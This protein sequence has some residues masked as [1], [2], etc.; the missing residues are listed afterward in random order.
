[1][2]RQRATSLQIQLACISILGLLISLAAAAYFSGWQVKSDSNLIAGDAVPGT[3]QAHQMRMVMTRGIGWVMVAASA[4]TAQSRD[5]SLKLA[6]DA[7]TAFEDTFRQYEATVLINPEEDKALLGRLKGLYAEFLTQRRAYEALILAG[8]K[9]KSAAFLE[10]SLVP[11]FLPAIEAAEALLNY[12]HANSIALA[13]SIQRSVR[14]LYWAVAVV[15]VMAL[16]CAGVLMVNVSIRR[17]ELAQLQE[18]EEKFSKVFKCSLSGIAITELETGRYLEVNESFCRIMGCSPREVIGRTSLE[19][20]IWM[21]EEERSQVFQPLFAG[22][23]LRGLERQMRIRGGTPRNLCINIELIELGGKRCM[24]SLI[25]DITE[26]KAADQKLQASEALFRTSFESA[27]VGVC[28]VATDGRFLNVN[29]TLCEMLGYTR[30]ELLQ[31]TFNDITHEEDKGLGSTFLND[32]LAGGAKQMQTEKRYLH[33]DGGVVWAFLSTALVEPSR[34]HEGYLISYVQDITERKRAREQL[35][36]LK[37]SIDTHLD[38]AFWM[39]TNNRFVYVNDSACE[40]LGYSREELLGQPV[41]LVA[42]H[43]T[44][45]TLDEVWE[46]LRETGFF[47]CESTHRRKDGSEFPVEIIASYVRFEG[48]EFN[49]GFARDITERKRLEQK[50][51]ELAAIVASSEDAIIGKSLTGVITSWN[52][53][54]ENIFGYSAEE[55]IGRPLL[56]LIPTDLQHEERDVLEK[57]GRGE[58]VEHF[59]TV[60]IRKDGRRIFISATISPFTDGLGRVVGASKIAR[61]VTAQK[62]AAEALKEKQGQLMLAMDIAK[63][64]HWEFDVAKK[65]I[66]GDEH[67]FQL[68]GTTSEREGGL[69]LSPREYIRRFVHP[70]DASLVAA[71]VARGTATTDPDFAR[72]FEHRVI[73]RDGAERVMMVRSRITMDAQGRAGKILGVNQDITEQKQAE[74]RIRHLNRVYEVLSD[75]NQ[76]IVRE[77]EPQVVLAEACRVL[78]EKGGFRMAWIGMFDAATETIQPITS[79]GAVDGYL[80]LLNIDLRDPER[81]GGPSGRCFLTGQHATCSDIEH[82]PFVGSLRGAALQ[83]GYRSSASFP[84]KVGDKVT[85]I[86]SLYSG[87]TGFFDEEELRLLD[88][89]AMDIGFAL[90]VGESEAKRRQ[91]EQELRWRTAFFEAQVHSAIDGILVVDSEGR[92]LLQNRRMNELWKIPPPIA[93]DPDDSRQFEFVLGQVKAPEAFAEK[94]AYLIARPDES[95]S[96]VIELLDGTLLERYSAPVR[97]S[98]G[99]HYGRVW[100]F[101]DITERKRLEQQFLRG[102]RMESI[103]TLAGGIAHDLNNVL[104]PIMMSIDLLRLRE[105]DP[106]RM[107]ILTTIQGSTKRGADMVKQVLSFAQGVVGQQVDIQVAPLLEEIAQIANNTFLKTIRLRSQIPP[108]L[109]LVRG[110]PTQLHQVLLNLC[111][112]ARDAMPEGGTLTLAASN[113][114]VD[115]QSTGLHIEAEPGPYVLVTVEDTGTGMPPEVVERIFEPFFTTKE[116]GK[117]TGLGLSTTLSIVKSHGGFIRVQSQPGVGTRFSVYLPARTA[118]DGASQDAAGKDLPHGQGELLLVVDDEAAVREITRQTL[119]SFGYRVLVASG[120]AEA[121]ALYAAGQREI[122]AVLTDL[123]MPGMDGPAAI[124]ALKEINPAVRVIAASGLNVENLVAKA[125]LAGATQFLPKPYTTD[126]MLKAFQTALKTS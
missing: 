44:A 12:N 26:R 66:T 31:L 70:E 55:A 102:Q 40:G 52:R 17:R 36:L 105:T 78:V 110:D 115:A 48:K 5:A 3:I 58:V 25:E 109:S 121:I 54:A 35:E 123:M 91:A 22:G 112:N 50:Q 87:E 85:G 57:I 93:D 10:Q 32:A 97:G 18:N 14:R 119:E 60:R 114:M 69:S 73:R 45:Q 43:A 67:V 107:E 90:E 94:A 24:V 64:A 65:T 42:P 23:S 86:F 21:S 100:T 106:K 120:G 56:M 30:D 83:R 20:G 34:E 15:M 88:E 111:V 4:Q 1:M 118:Q 122:R 49:C 63:L 95:S 8:D 46:S 104:A 39:D 61:D 19:L 59:E 38:G 108:D 82:D 9:E 62:R 101:H 72:Q 51:A 53:G 98:D 79:A 81:R 13:D 80:D 37:V 33:K 2:K 84:L 29:R 41:T 16:V 103:G 125:R 47:T 27:T 76:T 99:T 126:A 28:L 6:H 113:V 68:L 92:K 75:I 89:L 7:D 116:V 96:D 117:G 124:Q 77:K 11:A 71:E 74:R